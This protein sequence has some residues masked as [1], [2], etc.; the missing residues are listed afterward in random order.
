MAE[1]CCERD[2]DGDGNC[3][4]HPDTRPFPIQAEWNSKG[5]WGKAAISTIPWW[6]A[7]IAYEE[8]ARRNGTMQTLSRLAERGGFGRD[9]LVELLKGH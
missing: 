5:R 9:E 3:D 6:L 2:H 8:Y 1:K 7:Q 4:R